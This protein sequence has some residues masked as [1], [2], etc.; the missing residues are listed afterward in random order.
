MVFPPEVQTAAAI[1]RQYEA[2]ISRYPRIRSEVEAFLRDRDDTVSLCLKYLYG[3]MAA[4]D[5]LSHPAEFYAGYVEATLAACRQLAYLKTVP[6]DQ[7]R[8]SG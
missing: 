4:Q 7:F 5:V 1:L 3:H 8:V 2:N 6:P